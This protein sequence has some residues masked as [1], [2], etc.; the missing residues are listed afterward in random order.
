MFATFF[1]QMTDSRHVELATSEDGSYWRVVPGGRMVEVGAPNTWTAGDTHIGQGIVAL[2]NGDIAVPFVG[3]TETHKAYA[4]S[5]AGWRA[6]SRNVAQKPAQRHRCGRGGRVRRKPSPSTARNSTELRDDLYWIG[7]NRIRDDPDAPSR[8]HVRGCDHLGGDEMRCSELG[9]KL[10]SRRA[11]R[12]ENRSASSCARPRS[13]PSRS[14]DL[15]APR[16]YGPRPTPIP[17]PN[18]LPDAPSRLGFDRSRCPSVPAA[19][20]RSPLQHL[21]SR[22]LRALRPGRVAIDPGNEHAEPRRRLDALRCIRQFDLSRPRRPRAFHPN[23]SADARRW[24]GRRQVRAPEGTSQSAT[25]SGAVRRRRS[26]GA[27]RAARRPPAHSHPEHPARGRHGAGLC[28]FDDQSAARQSRRPREPAKRHCPQLFTDQDRSGEWPDRRRPALFG[29]G[30][31]RLLG[32]DGDLRPVD[33]NIAPL[34]RGSTQAR[35]TT[36]VKASDII[37]G[38][39]AIRQDPTLLGT[40]SLDLFVMFISGATALLPVFAKDVLGADALGLGILRAASAGGA[41]MKRRRFLAGCLINRAAGKIMLIC[42]A[43]YGVTVLVFGFSTSFW[44]SFGAL[45]VGGALDMVSVNVRESLVQLRT[46]DEL[47]GRV[48]SV[49]S[50][51]IG[52]SNELGDPGGTFRRLVRPG[53]RRCLRGRSRSRHRWRLVPVVSHHQTDRPASVVS[54][55]DRNSSTRCGPAKQHAAQSAPKT[56][57]SASHPSSTLWRAPYPIGRALGTHRYNLSRSRSGVGRPVHRAAVSGVRPA[58]GLSHGRNRTVQRSWR[59]GAS[60]SHRRLEPPHQ[61]L[62]ALASAS[63]PTDAA[64]QHGH[65][66]DRPDPL[67]FL[68]AIDRVDQFKPDASGCYTGELHGRNG[69]GAGDRTNVRGPSHGRHVDPRYT[70][71]GCWLSSRRRHRPATG[72]TDAKAKRQRRKDSVK[73]DRVELAVCPGSSSPAAS[74]SPPKTCCW[75]SCRC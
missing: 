68:N 11:H 61:L 14:S 1:R 58:P 33:D 27:V 41:F 54:T 22:E 52:A 24:H 17:V 19:K 64:R 35:P 47:R 70:G 37:G 8:V 38:F 59:G 30:H 39:V 4:I 72:C 32:R 60:Y 51:F 20:F 55:P 63:H 45:L 6:R 53:P 15:A 9:R 3:Y 56:N 5:E 34:L 21:R 44:L 50:V 23:A 42:V 67:P 36:A 31:R 49:N 29:L 62:D 57:P 16:P 65:P 18:R 43:G 40:I 26:A 10:R 48:T 12:S 73:P 2:P 75:S 69:A 28:E 13:L 46:P 74:A 7:C 66:R 25:R 71:R